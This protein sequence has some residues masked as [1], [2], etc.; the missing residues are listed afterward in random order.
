M[1][2]ARQIPFTSLLG[3]FKKSFKAADGKIPRIILVTMANTHDKTLSRECARDMKAVQT[4]FK[5]ISKHLKMPFCSI[6][7]A[8]KHYT[9]ENLNKAIAAI[10]MP[11]EAVQN[12]LDDL[13]IF[14]YTGHGFSY[15][16][17]RYA[18]Y[19]QLDIRPHNKQVKFNSIDFIK[20]HTINIENVL[21]F[22]RMRGGKITVAIADCCNT[23]IPYKRPAGDAQDM[24]ASG[25]MLPSKTKKITKQM[26]VDTNKEICILVASSQ[27]GQPAVTDTK[28][29]SLFTHFFTQAL[30]AVTDRKH[31]AGIYIPWPAILKKASAQAFKESRGY[32]V[33]GGVAGKQK[34]VYQ[35]YVSNQMSIE[36]R[37][38]SMIIAF[39]EGKGKGGYPKK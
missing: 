22:V 36:D 17:D 14:Y 38:L 28:M 5:N 1:A 2:V 18:K 10:P 31:K 7:V 37:Y 33:G 24:W 35:A 30:S 3:Q 34:A 9:W 23:I 15:Q 6:E 12:K 11:E 32:D 25:V 20:R 4:V 21:N 19:P 29:G 8:G 39:E 13:V 27:L 26:L 16:A